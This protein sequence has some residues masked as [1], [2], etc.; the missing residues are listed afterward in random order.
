ME[1]IFTNPTHFVYPKDQGSRDSEK[2][3]ARAQPV[4]DFENCK[5]ANLAGWGA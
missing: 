1:C 3:D 5:L 2:Q 4:G